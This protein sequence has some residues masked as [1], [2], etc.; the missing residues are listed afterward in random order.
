MG[1]ID[2]FKKNIIPKQQTKDV[3]FDD[4]VEDALKEILSKHKYYWGS[5]PNENSVFTDKILTLNNDQKALFIIDSIE[6]IHKYHYNRT[7]YLTSDNN[8]YLSEIREDFINHLFRTKLEFTDDQIGSIFLVMSSLKKYN[9]KIAIMQWP[10]NQ[11]I[12]LIEKKLKNTQINAKQ[13]SLLTALDEALRMPPLS[14]NEK[15]RIKLIDRVG[16]LIFSSKNISDAINPS[17]FLEDDFGAYTNQFIKDVTDQERQYWFKLIGICKKTSGAKPSDKFLEDG[18]NIYKEIGADK[19]KKVLNLWI[20]FIIKFKE[21]EHRVLRKYKNTEYTEIYYE[22]ISPNNLDT[23]K[24]LIW[25]CI[26]F[27]DKATIFNIAS[28]AERA[29]RKI[30]GKGPAA[31][32]LGNA[33]LYVLSETR[34]LDG[35]GHLSRL[36]LRIKQNN[37]RKIID[38]YLSVAAKNLGISI[39]EIEDLA[40]DDYDLIDGKTELSI[41]D[42]SAKIEICGIG[43]TNVSWIKNDG[44]LIKSVPTVV[45]EKFGEKLKKLKLQTK[46]IELSTTAQRDRIDRMLK[47]DRK[48]SYEKFDE[49]YFSHGLISFIARK[50]VW[51]F[52]ESEKSTNCIW[53]NG[54]WRDI[55]DHTV[56]LNK[57][58]TIV[59]L[60]HPVHSTTEEIKNWRNFLIQ[61]SVQQPVKQVFREVYILTDAEINTRTYSNRMA[62]HIVKQHQFNS[63]ANIRGWKYTLMGAFDNGMDNSKASISIPEFGLRAEFWIEE[64]NA[65]DAYNDAGIWNY[66]ATD[67]VRFISD[68]CT[69]PL[70]MTEVPKVIFSEIMRD[71]DLFVGVASVGNDPN[72]RDN[73]GLPAYRDYWQSYSFGD[74]SEIAKTRK[75]VLQRLLPK[76]RIAGISSIQDKFLI[77]KGK[78]RT[79]KIHIG[80]TN[81]LMEPNDQYLCIVPDRSKPSHD[82]LYLPFEGDTGLSIILSKAFLLAEDDK[83]TDTTI[84]SQINRK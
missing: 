8:Y 82:S 71:V 13:Q 26:N 45:K 28:L 24:P 30:P 46:Q 9:H 21:K 7:S 74:L 25:L 4:L 44:T 2:F 32:G 18:K 17:Y 31:A 40:S 39:A 11:L 83:I 29:Y 22:F 52:M 60:W 75:E 47:M 51:T 5:K 57:E 66:V 79:Y 49:F 63:L 55:N 1:L 80:S 27:Y 3:N 67:Q 68:S 41:G 37:T 65:E 70:Q 72:W 53:L 43:K 81:I 33:C 38:S 69:D 73:G 14:G 56:E 54:E 15:D 42:F 36:K 78:L 62:A 20:D 23:I 19:F 77:I 10:V 84:T 61:K 64:I 48:L 6:K 59:T 58:N 50:L 34:G 35:I 76:L 16:N 12:L